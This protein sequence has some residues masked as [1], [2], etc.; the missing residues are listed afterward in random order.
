MISSG[1]ALGLAA[2]G[3]YR[4]DRL[5]WIDACA[6]AV[7]VALARGR[8][9]L[10]ASSPRVTRTALLPVGLATFG[11]AIFAHVPPSEYIMGGKDPGV[12]MNEGIQIAQRGTLTIADDD[13]KAVPP[14]FRDLFFPPRG[15]IGYYSNRFMGFFLLDAT[16]GHVVGQFPQ[17]YPIWIALAYGLDG[18]SGGRFVGDAAAILGL[19][20]IYFLGAR[21]S[22]RAT[23]TAATALLSVHALQVWYARYPNAEIVMQPLVM[24]GILA[25]IRSQSDDDRFF[26][27]VAALLLVL[28]AFAHI[29]GVIAIVGVV[30]AAA[31]DRLA[32]RPLRAGFVVPLA[33]CGCLALLY[34]ARVLP[35]YFAL[36]LEYTKSLLST[37]R[38]VLLIVLAVSA[39]VAQRAIRHSMLAALVR[40]WWRP[41]LVAAVWA[42]VAYAYFFRQPAGALAPQDADALRTYTSFYFSPFALAAALVGF[43]ILACWSEVSAPFTVTV[44]LF[45]LAFFYKMRIIP[46]HF[47]AGRRF[48]A[49]T[50]PG[51]LLLVAVAAFHDVRPSAAR[52]WVGARRIT[53]MRRTAGTL[54]ILALGWRFAAATRPILSHVEYAGLIPRL[55]RLASTFGDRDLVI[56][57]ARGGSDV[58]VLALPL[59][60]I[61]A[62]HVLVLPRTNPDKQEFRLFGAW[63]RS[64][65]ARIFFMGGGGTELLSR[66]MSVK[67]VLSERFQIP[68]YASPMNEYPRG[69]RHKEFDLSVYELSFSPAPSSG[70]DLDVGKADDLFVRRFFAKE[71]NAHGVTFRWTSNVSFMSVLGTRPEQQEL[72]ITMSAGSRPAAAGPAEVQVMLNDRLLGSVTVH[73]PF[74][75]YRFSIPPDTAAALAESDNGGQLRLVTRTW[76]PSVYGSGDSRELGVMIDR[77]AIH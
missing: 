77:V 7:I 36:P 63:A 23:A 75:P 56:V 30:I 11:L 51:S 76:R 35:P 57:E 58:H 71:A 49:V 41:A 22:N 25:Y 4:F 73:E 62:R 19:L 74:E 9:H 72:T 64:H 59:A 68:E 65:Y 31:A 67:P 5:L 40:D 60:Y 44:T 13:V 14:P 2:A 12:Y 8:L 61:Y 6:C 47:W 37:S 43:L 50:L 42:G 27:P 32:G 20:A 28:S 26:G 16:T 34:F 1:A 70:F 52:A 10:G 55:E 66:S 46:E 54:V 33:A 3:W 15:E 48:L 24:S 53:L 21:I 18:L 17:L 69:V 45:A 29:T 38:I 39:A